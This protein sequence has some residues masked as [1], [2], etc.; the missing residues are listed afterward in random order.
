MR[1]TLRRKSSR[2]ICTSSCTR[3]EP[4]KEPVRYNPKIQRDS[5]IMQEI[6]C[7]SISSPAPLMKD[8]I[9]DTNIAQ[10]IDIEVQTVLGQAYPRVSVIV[11][12]YN[13]AAPDIL[14]PTFLSRSILRAI[15]GWTVTS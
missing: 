4:E 14:T 8:C 11:L 2:H 6:S 1:E 15:R 12:T 9:K 3:E 10:T 7:F 5:Q 13:S